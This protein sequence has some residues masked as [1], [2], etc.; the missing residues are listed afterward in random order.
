[1]KLFRILIAILMASVIL[2]GGA[3]AIAWRNQDRLIQ[4][5]LTRIHA[6]TG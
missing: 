2:V 3:F 5:V 6:E 4:V 1:M